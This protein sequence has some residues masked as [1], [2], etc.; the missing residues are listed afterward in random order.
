MKNN[1]IIM[2]F[3]MLIISCNAQDKKEKLKTVNTEQKK[4]G[5]P[6]LD[7]KVNK[8]YDSKGN[9]VKLDS[10]YSYFYSSKGRDSAKVSLDT[11]FSRFKSYYSTKAPGLINK[12]FNEMF[13]NDSLLKYDFGNKDFFSKRF[14]LN[15]NK[16]N[17]LF[18]KMDSLKNEFLKETRTELPKKL[19]T[20]K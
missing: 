3:L 2:I 4:E 18:F 6:K 10:T 11:A 14:E 12:N 15:Y 1:L 20:K 9:L 5:N 13:F 8:T 19:S 17:S 16:M 7:I